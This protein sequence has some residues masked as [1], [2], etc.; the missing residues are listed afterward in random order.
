L[1]FDFGV[2]LLSVGDIG[3]NPDQST[4]AIVTVDEFS[5]RFDPA[6]G[7]VDPSDAI[8]V[9]E[10]AAGFDSVVDGLPH[11]GQIL[12]MDVVCERLEAAAELVE[13]DAD[14]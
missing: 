13:I 8:L 1:D 2:T 6:V 3:R 10:A 12:P 14:E 11:G 5:T 9:L 7:A 4:A